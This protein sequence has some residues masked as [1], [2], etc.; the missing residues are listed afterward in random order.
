MRYATRRFRQIGVSARSCA[1]LLPHPGRSQRLA[2]PVLLAPLALLLTLGC[3]AAPPEAPPPPAPTLESPQPAQPVV[4]PEPEPEPSANPA[5]EHNCGQDKAA[6][7]PIVEGTMGE[8]ERVV[9]VINNSV[10]YVQA[11]LLD[12]D[13]KLVYPG[14]LLVS[15]GT[16]GEFR[17]P[18][19]VYMLRYRRHTNCEVMRGAPL[20]LKGRNRGVEISIKPRSEAGSQSKMKPVG[21]QL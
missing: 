3:A 5:V 9:R 13:R 16:K 10:E 18:A 21:E 19:G 14:T 11:R 4:E 1:R 20:I 7:Q 2:G 8:G 12:D 17:V 6:E 15:P